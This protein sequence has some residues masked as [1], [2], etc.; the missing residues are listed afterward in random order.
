MRFEAARIPAGGQASASP[1]E[2]SGATNFR[3]PHT[4]GVAERWEAPF[5]AACITNIGREGGGMKAGRK[6]R[7]TRF[8]QDTRMNLGISS[9]R[10]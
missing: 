1:Q 10:I 5:W 4:V 7:R 6:F 8:L 2:D 3:P 9:A